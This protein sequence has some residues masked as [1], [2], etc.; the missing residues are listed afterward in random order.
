MQL[1]SPSPRAS[2]WCLTF[3]YFFFAIAVKIVAFR[4]ECNEFA[5]M[6]EWRIEVGRMEA[7]LGCTRLWIALRNDSGAK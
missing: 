4:V 6:V 2:V 5:M 1:G 3:L 7:M